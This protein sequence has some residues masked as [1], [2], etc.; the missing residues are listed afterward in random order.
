MEVT[1]EPSDVVS[2]EDIVGVIGC[3]WC[4][5][6]KKFVEHSQIVHSNEGAP[7]WCNGCPDCDKER[8][9]HQ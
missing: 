3:G 2:Q 1:T 8:A 4:G 5:H 7:R 6:W 9:Q